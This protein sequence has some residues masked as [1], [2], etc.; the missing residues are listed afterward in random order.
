MDEQWGQRLMTLN[1]FIDGF[2]VPHDGACRRSMPTEHADAGLAAPLGST[3]GAHGAHATGYLR[4]LYDE[5]A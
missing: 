5:H 3:E 1:D 2:V 4:L